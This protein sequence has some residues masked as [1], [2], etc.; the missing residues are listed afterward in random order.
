M[1]RGSDNYC[2]VNESKITHFKPGSWHLKGRRKCFRTLYRIRLAVLLTQKSLSETTMEIGRDLVVQSVS[3][4][5][6]VG[7]SAEFY[8]Y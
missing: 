4:S 2:Y 5:S 7:S 1:G 6:P 8:V 3:S